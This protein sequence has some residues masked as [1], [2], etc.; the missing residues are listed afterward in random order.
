MVEQKGDLRGAGKT[1][2]E[3]LLRGG[4]VWLLNQKCPGSDAH[5]LIPSLLFQLC[6]KAHL[7]PLQFLS[8]Y[9]PC[10]LPQPQGEDPGACLFSVHSYSAV[11]RP[12]ACLPMPSE[13]SLQ[14]T[15]WLTVQQREDTFCRESAPHG[16]AMPSPQA[17][18]EQLTKWCWRE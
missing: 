18:T 4:G 15:G 7:L 3:A 9:A 6:V 17:P 10:P 16:P 11:V 8:N 2:W 12:Q 1:I 5:T 14:I 13:T